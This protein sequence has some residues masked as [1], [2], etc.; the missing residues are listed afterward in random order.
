MYP[1][2]LL[3]TGMSK[4]TDRAKDSSRDYFIPRNVVICFTVPSCFLLSMSTFLS[5]DRPIINHIPVKSIAFVASCVVQ[6]D[7]IGYP[8]LSFPG[9]GPLVTMSLYF[10]PPSYLQPGTNAFQVCTPMLMSKSRFLLVEKISIGDQNT[11]NGNQRISNWSSF[12]FFNR[13]N[14]SPK[15]LMFSLSSKVW[16][17]VFASLPSLAP[18]IFLSSLVLFA[19]QKIFP[20]VFSTP[21]HHLHLKAFLFVELNFS[22]FDPDQRLIYQFIVVLLP[23]AILLSRM[24]MDWLKKSKVRSLIWQIVDLYCF[25]WSIS[26]CKYL[27]PHLRAPDRF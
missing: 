9:P 20:V 7:I 18:S 27:C 24:V 11:V 6:S 1:C 17:S 4:I 16:A 22:S 23:N 19:G 8:V 21:L 13:L 15:F 3:I 2:M 5:P 12:C 25:N 10:V 14:Q 26:A